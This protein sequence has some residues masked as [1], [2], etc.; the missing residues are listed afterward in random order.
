MY[1]CAAILKGIV[2]LLG[3][4]QH[5]RTVFAQTDSTVALLEAS[6]VKTLARVDATVLVILQVK[7][8]T[9]PGV[10]WVI[11]IY[12]CVVR[13]ILVHPFPT[14]DFQ[15]VKHF[16]QFTEVLCGGKFNYVSKPKSFN[17]TLGKSTATDIVGA[18]LQ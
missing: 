12:I 7:S 10:P 13:N 9:D 17:N 8:E 16:P 14:H 5:S 18:A 3:G 1:C 6:K 4:K 15:S 2:G 11:F